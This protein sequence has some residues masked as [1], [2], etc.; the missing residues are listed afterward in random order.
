M[1]NVT[2]QDLEESEH[3]IIEAM[4]KMQTELLGGFEAFSAGQTIRLPRWRW[5][6]RTWTRHHPAA[7]GSWKNGSVK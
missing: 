7:S 4:R 2:K 3:R 6:N 5:I 1:N